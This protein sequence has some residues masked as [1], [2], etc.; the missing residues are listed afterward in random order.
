LN[1]AVGRGRLSGGAK[2]PSFQR[3]S[4]LRKKIGEKESR[5]NPLRRFTWGYQLGG[6]RHNDFVKEL[7]KAQKKKGGGEEGKKYKS[8]GK[9][10]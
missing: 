1:R 3:K 7:E 9:T 2:T 5:G 10:V 6:Q 8:Q 4:H